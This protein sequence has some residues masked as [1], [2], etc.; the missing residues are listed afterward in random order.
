ML[1]V[2]QVG[3]LL[4]GDHV[5]DRSEI[6]TWVRDVEWDLPTTTKLV[7]VRYEFGQS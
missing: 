6:R 4:F 3:K 2:T 7:E 5:I 1:I